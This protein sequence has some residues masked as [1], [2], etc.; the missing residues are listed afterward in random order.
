MQLLDRYSNVIA[1]FL[2][3]VLFPFSALDKILHWNLALQQADSSFLP[4]G[5]VLLVLGIV[6]ETATPLMIVLNWYAKPAAGL[7]AAFCAVTAV[8]YHNFWAYPGF[9][10]PSKGPALDHFWEFLKNFGLVGGLIFA[11]LGARVQSVHGALA[12]LK[13]TDTR[14]LDSSVEPK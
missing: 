9:W 1:R 5:A 11:T 4:G 13:R 3:V 12:S 10:D 2:L 8:L 14:N 6:I 7:L